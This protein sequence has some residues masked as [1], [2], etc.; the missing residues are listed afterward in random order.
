MTE[1]IYIYI[2]LSS[3]NVPAIMILAVL[4]I[5]FNSRLGPFE[6]QCFDFFKVRRIQFLSTFPAKTDFVFFCSI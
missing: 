5:K 1:V 3:L 2:Y 6:D 4:L